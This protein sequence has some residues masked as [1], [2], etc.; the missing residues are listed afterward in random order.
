[1]TNETMLQA[2]EW[3]LPADG[4]HWRRLQEEIPIFQK[5]G[6]TKVW[7]P[8]AFKG[9]GPNDVGYGVYDLFDLGEFDQNGT[10]LTKYGS[11]EDYLSL[12][13]S[14]KEAGI[15]PLADVVLNHKASGDSKE[16]FSVL[17]MDPANRQSPLSEPF[18]I[19]AWTAFTFP[20]RRDT[21][22]DFKWHWYHFTGV[23][24]DAKHDESGI[25]L[26][27]GDNKGWADQ[28]RIDNENG[29]F[30]YLMYDD[31]DFKHPEVVSHLKDW[32]KW[33]LDTSQVAGF[34]LDAVKH[35]DSEFMAEFIRYIRSDINPDFYVFGEYWKND[36]AMTQDYLE[37]ID[38]S[39]SLVD[40]VLHMNF[41]DAGQKGSQFNL[42]AVLDGSLMQASP[43]LAVTFVD[44]HDSQRGQALES[45]VEE[46]FKPL[47]YALIL[48]RQQ[49]LPCIFY[50]DYYG[51]SGDFAQQD[52][53]ELL[54]KLTFLRQHYVYGE[55]NDYFD[56]PNCIAWT[57]LGNEEHPDGLAVLLSNG[58]K[59][60]K[61]I[62]MGTLNQGKVFIDYLGNSTDEVTIGQDGWAEFP[63][64]AGSVSAWVDRDSLVN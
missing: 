11:K 5:L 56:H 45:T 31:L 15:M 36:A 9:T 13:Q 8:P 24:Y 44:N 14:L 50:G 12:I 38:Q 40:V 22:N 21:Y 59:G 10:V 33:F 23:D 55:Q 1:M 43:D 16:S 47:A 2:F 41:Y 54:D 58:D 49:G 34:R 37:Q 7:L 27:L 60:W 26:I 30:D 4:H 28:E 46:R 18:E 32:A 62:N 42:S 35:I 3:Y 6:L 53:R 29:N 48:L 25:Y 20:G 39:F 17:R 57:C 64:E 52:F 51:I 19:E 61:K 63:V